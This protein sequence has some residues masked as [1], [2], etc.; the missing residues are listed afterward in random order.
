M[1]EIMESWENPV[2]LY[3]YKY[4]LYS[5]INKLI[6]PRMYHTMGVNTST[7]DAYTYGC[8]NIHYFVSPG[9][10]TDVG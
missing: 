8:R 10:L 7:M 1:A 5:V 3:S 2:T 6:I 9:G 4:I